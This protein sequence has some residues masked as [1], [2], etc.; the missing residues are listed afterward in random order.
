[1]LGQSDFSLLPAGMIDNVMVS[2]GGASMDIGTGA[3]GG[4][5]NLENGAIQKTV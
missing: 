3:I 2:F 1:M 5:I 4:I